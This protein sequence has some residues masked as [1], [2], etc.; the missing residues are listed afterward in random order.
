MTS[1]IVC[2]MHENAVNNPTLTATERS[3]HQ[4]ASRSLVALCKSA[5]TNK[6]GFTNPELRCTSFSS[7]SARRATF[8][9]D[10]AE[11][12]RHSTF[13]TECTKH[14]P[15]RPMFL[16][17]ASTLVLQT[18]H[19]TAFSTLGV[20]QVKRTQRR[21]LCFSARV[22]DHPCMISTTSTNRHC[23]R[24]SRGPRIR[25]AHRW[26]VPIRCPP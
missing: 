25:R 4:F 23:R 6:K 18:C 3:S 26:S 19:T 24:R 16:T 15:E 1:Q 5:V 9:D 7:D 12:V 21:C 17:S 2:A 13:L 11:Q 20:A 14:S 22:R 10:R 8:P